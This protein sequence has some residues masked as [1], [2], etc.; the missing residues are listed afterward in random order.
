MV[1]AV[2]RGENGLARRSAKLALVL[3]ALDPAETE[4]LPLS[5]LVA[6]PVVAAGNGA[7][8]LPPPR[9]SRRAT[10]VSSATTRRL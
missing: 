9:Q 1:V 3:L 4:T 6:V 2:T 10:M 7:R 8:P 5:P